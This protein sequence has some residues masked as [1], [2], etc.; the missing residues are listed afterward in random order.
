MNVIDCLAIAPYFLT[1]FFMPP[2]ELGSLGDDDNMAVV[3]TPLAAAASE[4]PPPLE[5]IEEDAGIGEVGRI[6]QVF[7]IA[8]IMRIFKLARRS[9]GLQSIAY[10]VRTSWKGRTLQFASTSV[11]FTN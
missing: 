5:V 6:M 1:L 11:T 3:Q 10:T 8:R 4:E 2:T 7:R 9:V